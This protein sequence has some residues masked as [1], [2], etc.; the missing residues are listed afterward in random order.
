MSSEPE[1]GP[2]WEQP[3]VRRYAQGGPVS[4][5][6]PMIFDTEAG[7]LVPMLYDVKVNLHT[8]NDTVVV[9]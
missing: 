6:V 1:A 7:C 5:G 3:K 2:V 9:P 8:M 4:R